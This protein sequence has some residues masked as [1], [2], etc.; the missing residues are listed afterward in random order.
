LE[1]EDDPMM[2]KR[3][4]ALA[5]FSALSMVTTGAETLRFAY[6]KGEKYRILSKVYEA[7]FINGIFSHQAD[8]LNRIAVEVT[9]VRDGSGNHTVSY[10]TSERASGSTGTY[11]WTEEYRSVFWRDARGFYTIDPS[12]FMPVVRDVPLM[13]EEDVKPGQSWSAEG[14]EVHD[15]RRS[16]G[17]EKAFHFPIRVSYSYLGDEER[18]GLRC[19]MIGIRYDVFHRITDVPRTVKTYPTRIA[20][21]SDQKLWW[22]LD[23]R[24]PVY[25]EEEFDFLYTLASGDEVEYEGS[26]NAE[27]IGAE[28]LDKPK[29]VEEIAR[30][31][32]KIPDATVRQDEVGVTI[33]LENVRFP[34]NSSELLPEEKDKLR[35]IAEILSRYPDRDVLVTGF[36]AKVGGYT[37][38]ENQYLSEMRA[39]AAG[40]Y[41]LSLGVRKP[42]QLTTKGMGSRNPIGD[43]DNEEGRKKN[44]RVEI[45]ILEN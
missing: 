7:V 4:L 1:E 32:E 11:E 13:A 3:I 23:N 5:L 20:G 16:F 15:F 39:R 36:T 6:T 33:S 19:A 37:E 21:T 28:P 25:Y 8:I 35:R 42:E 27:V 2:R 12:Y 43:N 30:D 17:I 9:D 10:Q 22:D 14:S 38:E 31:I 18:D 45:T 40:D 34:P 44:R 41:L 29:M 24:R 26:A